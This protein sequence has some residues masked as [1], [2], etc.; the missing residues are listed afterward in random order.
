VEE[1]ILLALAL[2]FEN[3]LQSCVLAVEKSCCLT[4]WV[5]SRALGLLRQ[6]PYSTG[7]P[8]G[9]FFFREE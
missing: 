1:L 8:D 6:S 2:P 4:I 3:P 5:T 7:S 9:F